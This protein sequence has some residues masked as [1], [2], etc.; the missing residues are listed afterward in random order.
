MNARDETLKCASGCA[1]RSLEQWI[2]NAE[3]VVQIN[4]RRE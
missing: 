2:G 4:G 3:R 1:Q